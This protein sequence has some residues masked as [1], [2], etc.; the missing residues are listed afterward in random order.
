MATDAYQVTYPTRASDCWDDRPCRS[1][2]TPVLLLFL[3]R[4]HICIARLVSG[5]YVF[6]S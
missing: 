2:P 4:T 1:N 3:Q 6:Q 5:G